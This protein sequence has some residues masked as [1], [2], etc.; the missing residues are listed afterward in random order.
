MAGKEDS[1][2]HHTIAEL[3][4]LANSA[5]AEKIQRTFPSSALVRVHASPD[6]SRLTAFEG[7]AAKVGV[8]RKGGRVGKDVTTGGG[9]A[10]GEREG[11]DATNDAHRRRFA[12]AFFNREALF[13]VQGSRGGRGE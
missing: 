3:M 1:E 12:L 2:I 4:I 13:F 5:V 7:V 8:H 6:P 9:V 11:I 10:E